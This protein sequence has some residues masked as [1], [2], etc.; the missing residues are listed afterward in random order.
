MPS[1]LEKAFKF[2]LDNQDAIVAQYDGKFVVIADG[3]VKESYEDELVA[4]EEA[5][6]NY[7]PGNFL[8][9]LVS[10]GD[11]SYTQTFHSRVVFS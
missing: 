1:P 3:E 7:G 11:T 4:I 8:V 2:Y 6:K 10:P 5:R 9:Q